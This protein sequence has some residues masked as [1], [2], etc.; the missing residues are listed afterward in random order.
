MPVYVDI[1]SWLHLVGV[2]VSWFC[3]NFHDC[4]NRIIYIYICM[5]LWRWS[6]VEYQWLM[7]RDVCWPMLLEILKISNLF[8]SLIGNLSQTLYFSYYWV[9]WGCHNQLESVSWLFAVVCH[10]EVLNTCTTIWCT[11]MSAMLT[12][13]VILFKLMRSQNHSYTWFQI[14]SRLLYTNIYSFLLFFSF[15]DPGPHGTGRHMDHML[16]EIPKEDFRK[17]AQVTTISL[18][19]YYV[20]IILWKYM[21]D[22]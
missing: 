22:H 14:S 15:D 10:L 11:A 8:Y 21:W 19:Q 3:S 20:C 6:G 2:C 9:F 17:G 18:I 4:G 12:G 5:L 1:M 7:P 16:P 13:K